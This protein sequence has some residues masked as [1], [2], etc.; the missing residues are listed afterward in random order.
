VRSV[1]EGSVAAPI[2]RYQSMIS[3]GLGLEPRNCAHN[4]NQAFLASPATL[5]YLLYRDNIAKYKVTFLLK[6]LIKICQHL[7]IHVSGKKSGRVNF[8]V[9]ASLT[10][11]EHMSV[12][13]C[14]DKI[15]AHY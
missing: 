6:K 8:K 2:A 1:Y 10:K 7:S 12:R 4:G 13:N 15:M 14:W 9:L 5:Q 11:S 3:G